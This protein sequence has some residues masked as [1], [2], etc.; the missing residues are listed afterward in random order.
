MSRV[1]QKQSHK[2]RTVKMLV[3]DVIYIKICIYGF[4]FFGMW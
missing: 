2:P 4:R 1:Q 3:N